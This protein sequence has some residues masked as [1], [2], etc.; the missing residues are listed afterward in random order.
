MKYGQ[1]EKAYFES[2]PNRFI[3]YVDRLSQQEKV[4]VKNTGRCR[5]LLLPG[6]EVYLARGSEDKKEE[7][8]TKYDLVAV[9]KGKR[10]INMDSQA[11]NQAVYE[12]LLEKKLF[13]DLVSVR[14]ETTYGDSRFDFYVET[15]DEKIFLEVKGV[16]L[17]RDGVVLFPDAPSERAVKHV[18]EL[19]TAARNGFGAYLI[20]VI[21][22]QDV[23][24][25]MPNEET[26]PEFA[27]VLR[28]A[29]REG[30][31]I[32]A[33]DCQVTPQSMEIRKPVPVKL[34]L[35]DRI[36]KPLLSWYDRG[37]R[38]LPWREDPTPYHVWVSEIMLQQTRVEAGTSGYCITGSGRGRNVIKAVGRTWVL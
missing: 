9:K 17:E 15:Q 1:I 23:Q 32:L 13:P 36:E 3:A 31:K 8:K 11:P 18:K 16:T 12:W 21:Q 14:P 6:A 27:E 33:Y 26:Q 7:R 2:R 20:F 4:H 38:I 30:V 5:E 19:I 37:R 34:S 24:Y 22:M 29:R 28:E 25:F 10:I 35:L